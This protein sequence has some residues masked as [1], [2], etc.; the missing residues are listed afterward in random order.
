MFDSK[1]KFEKYSLKSLLGEYES[2]NGQKQELKIEELPGQRR[3]RLKNDVF[4]F[5]SLMGRW[6]EIVGKKLA[7]HTYPLKNKNKILYV[8]TD[9]PV[10]AEQLSFMGELIKQKIFAIFPSLKTEIKEL[11]FEQCEKQLFEKLKPQMLEQKKE[12]KE[13]EEQILHPHSPLYKKLKSE[14]DQV[15]EAI[16]DRELKEMLISLFIQLKT[17]DFRRSE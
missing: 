10:Y 7:E 16:K 11:K 4:D 5:L 6:D 13:I 8:L 9:H 14:A 12:T 17:K 15:F 1:K 2:A 3:K